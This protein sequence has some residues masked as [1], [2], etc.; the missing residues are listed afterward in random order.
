M[1]QPAS[2]STPSIG[3]GRRPASSRPPLE[4]VLVTRNDTRRRPGLPLPAGG[5]RCSRKRQ[6]RRLLIGEGTIDDH[7]VG[8][9]VEIRVGRRDRR[10]RTGRAVLDGASRHEQNASRHQRFSRAADRRDRAAVNARPRVKGGKLVKRDGWML[11]RV[12]GPGQRHARAALRRLT[13]LG[14]RSTARGRWFSSSATKV[15][16]PSV[17]LTSVAPRSRLAMTSIRIAI[18]VR[19]TRS[20]WA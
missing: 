1:R 9:K 15:N 4:R 10:P 8:E 20:T 18:E 2:R 13:A 16:R 19:P 14:L 11:W 3:C 7:T 5:S 17:T 12:R 6:G